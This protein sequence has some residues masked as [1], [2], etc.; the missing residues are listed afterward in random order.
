LNTSLLFY[1]GLT[2]TRRNLVL[3]T[4]AALL[5]QTPQAPQ[6]RPPQT[7]EEELSAAR[8]QQRRSAELLAK[9]PLPMATE[10]ASQFKA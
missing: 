9:V 1:T 10:P 2:M 7:P 8:D 3:A 4:P 6:Q 5:A